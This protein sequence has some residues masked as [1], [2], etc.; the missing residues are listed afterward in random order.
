MCL[1]KTKPMCLPI[2]FL[3]INKPYG[4]TSHDVVAKLRKILGIKKIGHS[5]TL[6]PAATGILIIGINGATRLFEYLPDDK[7]YIAEIAF[8]VRTNTDDITGEIIEKSDYIPSVDEIKENLKRFTGKILQ[9]PPIYS[10]V[11]ING[12]RAYS[13]ARKNQISQD[14]IKEKTVEIFSIPDVLFE[15]DKNP[16]PLL[17]VKIHCSS[18][19]YIRSLARDLG[20]RLG[21]AA[22]LYSLIRTRVG[23]S[24]KIEDSIPLEKI[25]P[26]SLSE[27]LI[28]PGKVLSLNKVCVA[29]SQI[30]DLMLGKEI[31]YPAINKDNINKEVQ[32]VDGNDKVI[33]IGLVSSNLFIKPKKILGTYE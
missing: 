16:Y 30:N 32:I 29:D 10:S 20:I 24:F 17:R 5:G 6:D 4:I 19:T 23:G 33:G 3:N 25:T 28:S 14:D 7:E 2:G 11:K 22:T 12:R 18:G 8:G 13:L 1:P 26:E 9:K 21:S 31:S 15:T 27:V